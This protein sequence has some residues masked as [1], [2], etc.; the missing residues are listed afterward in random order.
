[1]SVVPVAHN[2]GEFWP[3]N[4]F[5]KKPGTITVSIGKPIDPTGMEANAL[6]ALIENWIETEVVRISQRKPA[7]QVIDTGTDS[8]N[9]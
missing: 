5:I 2:A 8:N 9:A 6:N 7:E 3:R 4:A 1:T